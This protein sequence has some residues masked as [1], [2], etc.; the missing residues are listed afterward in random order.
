VSVG[1]Y[2][3]VGLAGLVLGAAF[4]ENVLPVGVTGALLSGGTI[5]L[6]SVLVAIEA[7]AAVVLVIAEIQEEPLDREVGP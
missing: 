2:T 6:L 4:L 7:A 5:Q 1:G 3:V